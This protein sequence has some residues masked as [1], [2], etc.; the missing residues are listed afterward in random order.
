VDG[1]KEKCGNGWKDHKQQKCDKTL[2][3]WSN[4]RAKNSN[5]AERTAYFNECMK[6]RKG[7]RHR[8]E[9]GDSK[10]TR[11]YIPGRNKQRCTGR[12]T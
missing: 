6:M 3:T 7:Q 4:N 11:T 5:Y 2:I 1:S 8:T 10:C 12:N 9:D